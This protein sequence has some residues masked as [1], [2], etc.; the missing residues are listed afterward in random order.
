MLLCVLALLTGAAEPPDPSLAEGVVPLDTINDL[1][2]LGD[3]DVLLATSSGQLARWTAEGV[4]RWRLAPGRLTAL[5]VDERRG[6]AYVG[7]QHGVVH[8]FDPSAPDNRAFELPGDVAGWIV[9][10]LLAPGGRRL[11]VVTG[12]HAV[13]L[14]RRGRVRGQVSLDHTE[15]G[16]ASRTGR[17]SAVL[18]N[19]TGW[20]PP[21]VAPSLY[22]VDLR[23]GTFSEPVPLTPLSGRPFLVM[24][25]ISGEQDLWAAATGPL[26]IELHRIDRATGAVEPGPVLPDSATG[27]VLDLALTADGQTLVMPAKWPGDVVVWDLSGAEPTLRHRVQTAEQPM[28]VALDGDT[29]WVGLRFG[30]LS[31]IDLQSGE[32]TEL[33]PARP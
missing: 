15:G 9:D 11:L 3:Q 21:G 1:A 20:G 13:V 6:L 25:D 14:D 19:V 32:L 31:R 24:P 8:V 16:S 27:T 22:D 29:A 2:V 17:R 7:D 12:K 4:Q 30:G 26:D 28:S 5:A 33:L 23:R 18:L 10:L